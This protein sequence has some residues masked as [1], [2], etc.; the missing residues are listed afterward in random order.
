MDCPAGVDI[1]RIFSQYNH[2]QISKNRDTF[3]GTYKYLLEKEKAHNCVNCGRC[4]K[5]CPQGIDIPKHLKAI[6][7]FAVS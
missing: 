3:K 6:A 5:L 2:Y 1:P 7:E 4:V